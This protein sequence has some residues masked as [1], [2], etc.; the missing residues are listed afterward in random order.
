MAKAR[1]MKWRQLILVLACCQSEY[2]RPH[3]NC[4]RRARSEWFP[5]VAFA[6]RETPG[7]TLGR[8]PPIDAQCIGQP[9]GVALRHGRLS[10]PCFSGVA[11][12]AWGNTESAALLTIVW[13]C[14]ATSAVPR[15]IWPIA[16]SMVRGTQCVNSPF[17]RS[18]TEPRRHARQR[19]LSASF[20]PHMVLFRGA[21][22]QGLEHRR[23]SSRPA[24][25]TDRNFHLSSAR[26]A[27]CQVHRASVT[28]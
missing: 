19:F 21:T 13:D 23:L 15:A 20:R 14:L 4:P 5:F 6:R 11:V 17:W 16:P 27:S 24:Q 3:S 9:A 2:R 22:R 26:F 25:A 7:N 28:P 1:V 8:E 10:L 12:E 18:R